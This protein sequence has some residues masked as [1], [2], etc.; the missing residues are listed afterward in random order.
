[1]VIFNKRML[2]VLINTDAVEMF[3]RYY[4]ICLECSMIVL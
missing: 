2:I 1:M 3:E 4:V